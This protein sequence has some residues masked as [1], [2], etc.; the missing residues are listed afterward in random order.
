MS[1]DIDLLTRIEFLDDQRVVLTLA[2]NE[3]VHAVLAS[4]TAD[5]TLLALAK[6][7]RERL[8]L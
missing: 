7:I 2:L 5:D 8:L 6:R 3:M 4:R 1:D